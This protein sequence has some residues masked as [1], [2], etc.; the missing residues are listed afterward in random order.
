[1]IEIGSV[2]EIG[3]L[4]VVMADIEKVVANMM[5]RGLPAMSEENGAVT[6]V[7]VDGEMT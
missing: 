2:R 4:H 1:V 5:L 7:A 6:E 3:I